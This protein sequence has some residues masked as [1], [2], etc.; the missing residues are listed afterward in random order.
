MDRA[1]VLGSPSFGK[2]SVQSV[3]PLGGRQAALKL[4]TALYRTPSGRAIHKLQ[5]GN[6]GGDFAHGGA[7]DGETD[8]DAADDESERPQFQTASGRPVYGGGGI[9]PDVEVV[10]D[11]LQ[12]V[13]LQVERATLPFKFSNSWVN[14]H[15]DVT[16]SPTVS[17]E[18]WKAYVALIRDL[19]DAPDLEQITAE[20][21]TLERG[22]RRELARRL[23][24]NAA[25]ARVA[26]EGDP[27]FQKASQVLRRA[28][29]PDDVFAAVE[30]ETQTP[31]RTA[32]R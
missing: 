32:S 5:N 16:L 17:A 6:I 14:T 25:A 20:R 10:P 27:I 11:S 31:S 7:D 23:G 18:Q 21:S 15:D 13:V 1:L 8:A 3:F 26:L 9:T 29:K 24:G 22:L 2:G 4:T 30:S 28:S 12:D 19:E